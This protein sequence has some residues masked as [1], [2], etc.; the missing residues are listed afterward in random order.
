MLFSSRKT[1]AASSFRI[2]GNVLLRHAVHVDGRVGVASRRW[3]F[4][5]LLATFDLFFTTT[6]GSWKAIKLLRGGDLSHA[7][8]HLCSEHSYVI[9][10]GPGKE[11]IRCSLCTTVSKNGRRPL[12]LPLSST[13]ATT[14]GQP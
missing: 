12:P 9:G 6:L 8:C 2:V 5:L 4:L 3:N 1:A 7:I 11:H 13:C 10:Y 14:T